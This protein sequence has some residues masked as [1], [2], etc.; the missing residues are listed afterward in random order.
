MINGK[1]YDN[2]RY[3]CKQIGPRLSGSPQAQKAV[4][5]T[6]KMLKEAGADTVYMQPCMVPHWVRGE[7]ETGW[8]ELAGGKKYNLNLCAVGNS[9]GT[10]KKGIS[11]AV[12]EVKNFAELDQ[13]GEAV[14]G[15]IVFFNF[16]MNPTYIRTFRAYGESGIARRAGASQAG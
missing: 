15:K 13:L 3:L 8:I 12:V 11:A 1:A 4:Q 10:G 6:A 5:A 9:T 16:A 7:K 14:R 2:L